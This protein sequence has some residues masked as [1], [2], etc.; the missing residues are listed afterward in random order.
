MIYPRTHEMVHL[1][2]VSVT[3]AATIATT[4][5]VK[6]AVTTRVNIIVTTI[7]VMM[8]ATI[9]ITMATLEWST[10][11]LTAMNQTRMGQISRRNLTKT[12]SVP[13]SFCNNIFKNHVLIR[14]THPTRPPLMRYGMSGELVTMKMKIIGMLE[15]LN[16]KNIV[17][18]S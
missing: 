9:A 17:P 11:S 13:N 16:S 10:W 6:A 12:M 15:C 7:P 8:M 18:L 5:A 1:L 14:C 4:T 2:M 3:A